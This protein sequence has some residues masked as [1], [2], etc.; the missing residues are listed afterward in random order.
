M[1]ADKPTLL[2]VDD[3]PINLEIIGEFLDHQGYTL[4]MADGGQ[5]ALDR[6]E[7][8]PDRYDIIILDRMMPDMDGMSV[9]RAVKNNERLRMLPVIMQTAA[10]TPNA[11]AEGLA[12][13]AWYYL[14]K[15]Y[16]LEALAS[17][18]DTALADRRRQLEIVGML[19]EQRNVLQLM[20]RAEFCFRTLEE[21][22]L[23][24]AC[25][26]R[27][28]PNPTTA[29]MGLSELLI[30]AVE[31]GNL[32]IGYEGKSKLL[33]E[34]RWQQ[35]IAR[36]LKAP[37]NMQKRVRVHI[38]RG[39]KGLRFVIH[40]EGK[41]FDSSQYLELTTERAFDTHG[42]GIALARQLAFDRLE[43]R[44]CG[45]EAEAFITLPAKPDD[46]PKP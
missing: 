33:A 23:V 44:G 28:C 12:A 20:D 16:Q 21:A 8:E 10:N 25:L 27:A 22:N 15:P 46:A 29:A 43:Y 36:R 6:L 31:H 18:V 3:D 19:E 35:E 13:G 26:A 38:D 32:G 2:V 4:E 24:A 14:T 17:I 40:D 42:R 5:S 37:E 11:V 30:N 39:E 41:G 34:N 7:A 1:S 9:L 45:N